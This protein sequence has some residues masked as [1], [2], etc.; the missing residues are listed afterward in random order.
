MEESLPNSQGTHMDTTDY[1]NTSLE[2][3]RTSD[4]MNLIQDDCLSTVLDIGARDG[5]FSVLLAEK[6]DEVYAIDIEY[7][8][9]EHQKIKCLHGDVTKLQFENNV[10]DLVFCAEVLEHIQ[11]KHLETACNEITR[12]SNKYIIIGVP[13]KQDIRIG[14]TKCYTCGKV[15][16]PWGHI[17]SFDEHKIQQ[18]FKSCVIKKKSFVGDNTEC[19][20]VFSVALK[21][22]A[23]YPFGTYDQEE[24]CIHC[25]NK[26]IL[27]PSRNAFQKIATRLGFYIER[28]QRLFH[29]SHPN[30]IHVLLE[31][32][33]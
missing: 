19:T 30:W 14:R 4:L 16:P 12:V 22:Y 32:K 6:F 23:G 2:K 10:F 17:N 5:W 7:P 33:K 3:A 8:L 18:L 11:E 28:V 13:F 20:N 26:L 27:P 21:G 24:S 15:N 9:I 31:K 1:R 29:N 25:E